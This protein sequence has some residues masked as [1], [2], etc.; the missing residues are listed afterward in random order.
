[1]A[2]AKRDIYQEVTDKIISALEGGTIPWHKPWKGNAVDRIHRNFATKRPYRGVNQWLL[3]LAGYGSSEWMTY[4]Q[5]AEQVYKAW[6]KRH[7]QKNTPESFKAWLNADDKGG[8]RKGEKSTL[9]V[10]FK[11]I[12]NGKYEKGS[13]DPMKRNKGI[14][15]LRH[16]NVFNVE[17]ID[18]LPTVPFT[19]EESDEDPYYVHLPEHKRGEINDLPRCPD[20][21]EIWANWAEAPKVAH[22]GSR[23]FYAPLLDSITLPAKSDFHSEEHYWATRFHEGVHATGHKDRL[24][25]KDLMDPSMFGSDTYSKEE[26]TAEL[27]SAILCRL[28][29]IS[30]E[31]LVNNSAAYIKNWLSK[32]KGDKKFIVQASSKANQAVD[33]IIGDTKDKE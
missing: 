30:S 31:G 25:R 5:A 27:G 2:K 4:K 10:F 33:H 11:I 22:R 1:M 32:L 8:V 18:G 21:E 6:L 12:P 28:S 20:A 3:D 15:L 7:D 29:H 9:V 16:F 24:N 14:P 26:L 23:A 13:K 19:P 17:Q